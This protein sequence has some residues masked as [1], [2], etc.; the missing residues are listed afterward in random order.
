MFDRKIIDSS[1]GRNMN[2]KCTSGESLEMTNTLFL[3]IGGDVNLI[4]Q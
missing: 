2:I 3:D 4:I 1:D